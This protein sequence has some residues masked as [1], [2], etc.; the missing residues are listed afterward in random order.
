MQLKDGICHGCLL[1][2][3]GGQ[4]LYFFSADNEMD[5][6]IAAAATANPNSPASPTT[7]TLALATT[8]SPSPAGRLRR[9]I[10]PTLVSGLRNVTPTAAAV[11]AAPAVSGS[12]VARASGLVGEFSGLY[13]L[14][15]TTHMLIFACRVC[16]GASLVPGGADV[17]YCYSSLA[18][19]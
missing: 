1:K 11:P 9:W 14:L 2:D 17:S 13:S 3:K 12:R 18:I 6:G 16:S 15:L 8:P 10:A 19:S 7:P 5:L 4:T